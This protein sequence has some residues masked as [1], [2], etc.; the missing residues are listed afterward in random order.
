MSEEVIKHI[1][2]TEQLVPG[3]EYWL[4]SKRWDLQK[5]SECKVEPTPEANL[6]Y[7]ENHIWAYG[8]NNQAMQSWDIFGPLPIRI[9]PDFRAL[10]RQAK[11]LAKVH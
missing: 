4:V 6:K 10:K 5:I 9:P 2:T 8:D 7:F 11:L 1:T 3:R